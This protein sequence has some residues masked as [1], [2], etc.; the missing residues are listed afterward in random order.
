MAAVPPGSSLSAY[1]HPGVET[2][3]ADIR[4]PP[5][6]AG[7]DWKWTV[8]GG[9]WFRLALGRATFTTSAQAPERGKSLL[10]MLDG[11]GVVRGR[12]PH[13]LFSSPSKVYNY[14]YNVGVS[15]SGEGA[16]NNR[17]VMVPPLWLPPGWSLE[18]STHEAELGGIQSE[19]QWSNIRLW[20]EMPYDTGQVHEALL[21]DWVA[22]GL[23]NAPPPVV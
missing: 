18:S 7:Q 21:P 6:P 17:F 5:P 15:I 1:V 19:D 23:A 2:V 13:S 4:V 10:Q 9:R 20:A 8:P 11:D 14:T 16:G 22:V 12:F 3:Y